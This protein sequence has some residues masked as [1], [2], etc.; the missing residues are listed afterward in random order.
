MTPRFPNSADQRQSL[1]SRR[2]RSARSIKFSGAASR[3]G[4]S[5]L[6]VMLS[7]A[8]LGISM[9]IIGNL[10]YLGSRSAMQARLRSDANILC[11]TKMA[12]LAAGILPPNSVGNQTIEENP[13]WSYALDIQSSEQP[14]LLVATV[15]VQQSD[16]AAAVP[17]SMSIVRFIPDPDYDPTEEQE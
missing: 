14:G 9:A 15:T 11:D 4:L 8:I 1:A 16:S 6:E 17:V 3:C 10:F 13:L 7:I 2:W 12:E 5:L